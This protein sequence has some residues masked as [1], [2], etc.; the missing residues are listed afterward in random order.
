MRRVTRPSPSA[1]GTLSALYPFLALLAASST[2]AMAGIAPAQPAV[3]S[4]AF[5]S[6][7]TPTP[8]VMTLEP[9]RVLDARAPQPSTVSL[10][11]YSAVG[12]F[13]H[14]SNHILTITSLTDTGMTPQ[15]CRN[16]CSV[17]SAS[18]FGVEWGMRCYCGNELEPFAARAPDDECT[19]S[20]YGATSYVCGARSRMNLYAHTDIHISGGTSATATGDS[21]TP[22]SPTAGSS[23][24]S[25]SDDG[26][27]DEDG[28]DAAAGPDP[29]TDPSVSPDTSAGT[30]PGHD[31][32]E[33]PTTSA[34]GGANLS[35]G[36]VVGIAIGAAAISGSITAA[37]MF[38]FCRRRGFRNKN[39]AVSYPAA[40]SSGGPMAGSSPELEYAQVTTTQSG[41]PRDHRP[42]MAMPYS[43][44]S[45][46]HE[47]GHETYEMPGNRWQD[48]TR[49]TD[50]GNY[51]EA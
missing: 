42:S 36:A 5:L 12:C 10:A 33:P 20:C 38:F 15:L 1:S 39:A 23:S 40:S 47:L 34:P 19:A 49:V 27:I 7:P 44:Q 13:Q 41:R 17:E 48:E 4:A 28:N 35:V 16:F 14:G 37:V 21:N 29:G 18:I 26:S 46:T 6:V 22:P 50:I 3:N 45:R 43:P 30:S 51:K 2:M 8:I 32:D 25:S 24:G 9:I 11:G 31:E